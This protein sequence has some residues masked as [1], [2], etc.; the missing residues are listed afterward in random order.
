MVGRELQYDIFADSVV[1]ATMNVT[2]IDEYGRRAIA[3]VG[4]GEVVVVKKGQLIHGTWK[5]TSLTDRTRWYDTA[6]QEISL[7]PGKIWIE[8]VPSDAAL[9]IESGAY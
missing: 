1:F 7:S 3:T 8:I 9:T 6:G 4:S 2:T 5:K